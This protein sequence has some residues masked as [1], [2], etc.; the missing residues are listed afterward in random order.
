MIKLNNGSLM[1]QMGFG[2]FQVGSGRCKDVI[3]KAVD[4]GFRHFDD[5]AIYK[6]E[7]E[8]G[9]AISAL[10][11]PRESLFL[12]S[13]LWCTM[14]HPKDVPIALDRTLKDLQTSYLDLYLI[15]WPF[16]LESTSEGT[17]FV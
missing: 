9:E 17:T 4:T 6:N 5:A 13:K 16:A 10:S 7:G 14:Q 12:T 3:S 8:V 15:H 2:L 1:P 11:I